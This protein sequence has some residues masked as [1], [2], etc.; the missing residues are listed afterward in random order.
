MRQ[1]DRLSC[2][3]EHVAEEEKPI[4]YDKNR[5]IL[6]NCLSLISASTLS[7]IHALAFNYRLNLIFYFIV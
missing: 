4:I 5:K 1:V 7:A 2:Q 6:S 3:F